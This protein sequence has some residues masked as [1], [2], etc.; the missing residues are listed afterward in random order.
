MTGLPWRVE[1]AMGAAGRGFDE[2]DCDVPGGVLSGVVHDF[3]GVEFFEGCEDVVQGVLDVYR[4]C[5]GAVVAV[6]EEGGDESHGGL[7]LR[8]LALGGAVGEPEFGA[9]GAFADGP[10]V[11]AV[12]GRIAPVRVVVPIVLGA[13][14]GE[15]EE[16]VEDH[17]EQ[18][19]RECRGGERCEVVH[20]P[21]LGVRPAPGWSG[22]HGLDRTRAQAEHRLACQLGSLG[23]A[24]LAP[25]ATDETEEPATRTGTG[26]RGGHGPRAGRRGPRGAG[27]MAWRLSRARRWHR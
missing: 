1:S 13:V 4:G 9:D 18:D 23:M 12:V 17:P 5:V 11:G 10:V 8:G 27:G 24:H 7:G 20:V 16:V 14:V 6:E 3:E 21:L 26:P 22:S 25:R 2:F 19:D 15:S